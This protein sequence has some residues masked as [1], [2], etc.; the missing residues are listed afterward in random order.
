MMYKNG[1]NIYNKETFEEFLVTLGFDMFDLEDVE[2]YYQEDCN[3]AEVSDAAK[4][5]ERIADG[6]YMRMLNCQEEIESL[7]ETMRGWLRGEKSLR[8]LHF[9]ETAVKNMFD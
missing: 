4:E 6:N 2:S 7:T 5:W 1:V 3:V 9:I 8:Y